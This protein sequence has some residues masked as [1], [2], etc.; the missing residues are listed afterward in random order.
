MTVTVCPASTDCDV[1]STPF[2]SL[3]G[4]HGAVGCNV[5]ANVGS[6]VGDLVGRAVGS[7]VG[8]KV[9]DVV[10]WGVGRAVGETVGGKVVGAAVGRA[11]GCEV[12]GKVVGSEVGA[13]VGGVVGGGVKGS[14]G[15]SVGAAVG[16]A[17][18]PYSSASAQTMASA[19]GCPPESSRP[20]LLRRGDPMPSRLSPLRCATECVY[21]QVGCERGDAKEAGCGGPI[22]GDGRVMVH[23]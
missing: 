17:A 3:K 9:G 11:V 20:S 10:G 13:T 22:V 14:V 18:P 23:V 5:G 1:D 15:D 8:A 16:S 19:V 6:A 12:G 7:L 4:L 2:G 21:T